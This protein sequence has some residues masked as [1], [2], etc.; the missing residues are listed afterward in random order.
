MPSVTQDVEVTI[1]FEVW[2]GTCGAGL[3]HQTHE[4]SGGITVDACEACI[5]E[6]KNSARSEGYDEGYEQARSEYGGD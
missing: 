2:C 1:D 6:A 3:C 5:E 4:R